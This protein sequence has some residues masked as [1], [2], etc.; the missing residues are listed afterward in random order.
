L[1]ERQAGGAGL[2]AELD[3]L[4]VSDARG[5]LSSRT[6]E[7]DDGLVAREV[8][9]REVDVLGA[10]GRNGE[11]L[12]VEVKVLGAGLDG[13]VEVCSDPGQGVAFEA[14]F[15][16]NGAH[17]GGLE[18]FA[19]LG[20]IVDDPG[21]ER[22]VAGRCGEDAVFDRVRTGVGGC[23]FG[24]LLDGLS[25][26]FFVGFDDLFGGVAATGGEDECGNGD[27]GYSPSGN[28]CS[29]WVLLMKGVH[30]RGNLTDWFGM[31]MGEWSFGE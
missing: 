7:A 19:G 17:N 23:F 31:I 30:V 24:R 22:R 5:A 28:G 18:S 11:L 2:G 26:G 13:G 21:E 1:A 29:H 25:N 14:H 3:V 27:G 12:D 10:L 6:F 15:V 20:G 16:G 4:E 8:R 9:Q